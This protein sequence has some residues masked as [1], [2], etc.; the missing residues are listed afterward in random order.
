MSFN[1]QAVLVRRVLPW[2]VRA[3]DKRW[4]QALL[5]AAS[6]LAAWLYDVPIA[7]AV[8]VCP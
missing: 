7:H 2:A 6:F 8:G 4:V 5:F 1:P 3:L